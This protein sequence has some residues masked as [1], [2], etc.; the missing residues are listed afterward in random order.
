[1]MPPPIEVDG[2]TRDVRERALAEAVRW[3]ASSLADAD[4]VVAAAEKFEA[5]L[6]RTEPA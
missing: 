2:L 1:M 4:E 5:F 3:A 6:C